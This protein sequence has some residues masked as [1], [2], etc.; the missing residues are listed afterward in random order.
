MGTDLDVTPDAL[1]GAAHIRIV[2]GNAELHVQEHNRLHIAWDVLHAHPLECNLAR[3]S[4]ATLCPK[5]G[6]IPLVSAARQF[7]HEPLMLLSSDP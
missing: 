2:R 3:Q 6:E 5:E 7:G 1:A 4:T